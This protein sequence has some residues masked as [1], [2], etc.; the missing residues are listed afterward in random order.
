MFSISSI[1]SRLL[2]EAALAYC[3]LPFLR[4]A[5][6]ADGP[7]TKYLGYCTSMTSEIPLNI[8]FFFDVSSCSLESKLSSNVDAEK[9]FLEAPRRAD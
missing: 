7:E 8:F 1:R 2:A 5:R 3:N 4:P 9:T 6:L